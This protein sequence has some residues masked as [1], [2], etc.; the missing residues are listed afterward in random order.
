METKNQEQFLCYLASVHKAEE[1]IISLL[2]ICF[3]IVLRPSPSWR[4]PVRSYPMCSAG[5][6]FFYH[7]IRFRF[8]NSF[9]LF[10]SG[11]CWFRSHYALSFV[12]P[13]PPSFPLDCR[14]SGLYQLQFS[15]FASLLAAVHSS[16]FGD[17]FHQH[18]PLPA[19]THPSS[20]SIMFRPA[21]R[22]EFSLLHVGSVDFMKY[23]FSVADPG[24]GA[25]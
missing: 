9:A 21:A 4:G 19:V 3:R 25:L 10:R 13:L 7:S 22:R 17:I 18:R 5:K 6:L 15:P 14:L 23:T 11:G 1:C 20:R 8:N 2:S 12:T 16:T 24:P